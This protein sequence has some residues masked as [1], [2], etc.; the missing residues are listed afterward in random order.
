MRVLHRYLIVLPVQRGS[1]HCEKHRYTNL[2]CH[3]LI[4][5]TAPVKEVFALTIHSHPTATIPLVLPICLKPTH[6]HPPPLQPSTGPPLPFR[7]QQ[8]HRNF[9]P[10]ASRHCPPHSASSKSP[11]ILTSIEHAVPL[12]RSLNTIRPLSSSDQQ[13]RIQHPPAVP[14]APSTSSKRFDRPRKEVKENSVVLADVDNFT[15]MSF[16]AR[17]STQLT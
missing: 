12:L 13:N 9:Q 8:D 11:R 4:Q 15:C 5:R 14:K 6:P 17:V 2:Y 16:T 7:Q 10:T 1:A 3:S